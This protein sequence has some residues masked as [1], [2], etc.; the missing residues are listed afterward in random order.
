[1]IPRRWLMLPKTLPGELGRAFDRDLH[2]RLEDLR[3]RFAVDLPE[4]A[5]GRG[6][7]G[8]SDESTSWYWP[9]VRM[10]RTPM[11]GK[12]ISSPFFIAAWNPLSQA[13]MNSR[14]MRPPLTSLTNS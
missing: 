11:T 13:G 3:L 12:P 10:T 8:V 4:R 5:D 9:S 1:M 6:L 7:E 2:D 14:G